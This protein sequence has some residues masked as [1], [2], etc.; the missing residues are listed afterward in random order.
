MKSNAGQLCLTP[1][2]AAAVGISIEADQANFG[3]GNFNHPQRNSGSKSWWVDS[4]GDEVTFDEKLEG[5]HWIMRS[6]NTS[7]DI[8]SHFLPTHAAIK[9]LKAGHAWLHRLTL[10]S[11]IHNASSS[12]HRLA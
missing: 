9:V 10:Q 2:I 6:P 8:E 1:R 11:R 3:N 4:S 5:D 12:R 7:Y